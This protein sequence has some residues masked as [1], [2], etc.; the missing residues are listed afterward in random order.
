MERDFMALKDMPWEPGNPCF[1]CG[2]KCCKKEGMSVPVSPEE[3]RRFFEDT[4]FIS[5]SE[6]KDDGGIVR[7]GPCKH[8]VNDRCDI[9]REERPEAC[10]KWPP[11]PNEVPH[12]CSFPKGNVS[13]VKLLEREYLDFRG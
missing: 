4:P 13:W 10:K 6:T 2:A 1:E 12:Y 3:K 9:P 11:A 7:V 8:L 5:G